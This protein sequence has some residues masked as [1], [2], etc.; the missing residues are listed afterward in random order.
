LA[1]L[2]IISQQILAFPEKVEKI[3][4]RVSISEKKYYLV[5][6]GW[7]QRVLLLLAI[8]HVA[9]VIARSG[10]RHYVSLVKVFQTANF[11]P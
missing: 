11:F 7:G 5:G 1:T 10:F 9:F 8:A 2:N 3:L 4:Q 6:S